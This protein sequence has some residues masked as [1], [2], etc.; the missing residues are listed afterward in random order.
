MSIEDIVIMKLS[1][2]IAY[3]HY[4]G[5]NVMFWKTL[6]RLNRNNYYLTSKN[7]QA[8]EKYLL[9]YCITNS[10]NYLKQNNLKDIQRKNSNIS[11]NNTIWTLWW[12]GENKA[13]YI[14]KEC[15]KS[16]REH[17]N[18]HQVIVIDQFN[19]KD[20]IDIPEYILDRYRK[21][22]EDKSKLKNIVL[23]K[24]LLADIIRCGV[25]A[26]YGGIWSDAT[27]FFSKDL[28][29]RIFQ[30]KWYTLGQDDKTYVGQGK[31]STFFFE[32]RNNNSLVKFVFL[33]LCEYWKKK[34]YYI[35]YLMF[36]YI[37]DIAYRID[38]NIASMINEAPNSKPLTINRSYNEIV[39]D[40]KRLDYFIKVQRFHKLSYKW[41]IDGNTPVENKNGNKTIYGFL[42]ENYF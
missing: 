8:I 34:E 16:M 22:Q 36:D 37:I 31:W 30:R 25:L 23:S 14:V 28:D 29:E 3:M 18:G 27:I 17:A 41:W 33:A 10:F 4:F 20:Y 26:S 38:P 1:E 21:G 13:P 40:E 5:M 42:K 39:T 24:P 35:N 6:H 19:Y 11:I 32:C 7:T 2:N 9:N 15:I 12:Q